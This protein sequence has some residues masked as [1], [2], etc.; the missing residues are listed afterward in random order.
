MV[1][2]SDSESSEDEVQVTEEGINVAEVC[3]KPICQVVRSNRAYW[4]QIG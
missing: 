4:S 2:S 3:D 1:V